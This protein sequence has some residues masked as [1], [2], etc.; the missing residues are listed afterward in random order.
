MGRVGEEGGEGAEGRSF[1]DRASELLQ[2][3][4]DREEMSLR[5][6]N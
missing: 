4:I 5:M 2:S 1:F 6:N 3:Q